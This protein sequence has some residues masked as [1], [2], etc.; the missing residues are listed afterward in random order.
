MK[1]ISLHLLNLI[2][3]FAVLNSS[4]SSEN[5]KETDLET[6]QNNNDEDVTHS[7][8]IDTIDHDFEFMPPSPI[9]IASILKKANMTYED[10]LTNEISNADIYSTKFKQ[11]INFG[12]YACDLAYCVTNDKYEEAGKYLKVAKKMSAKIG[13]ESIFQ[14]DH[15]VERFEKNIGN[16]DSIMDI[17]FHVQ[18]MTDDY[19]HDNDL[20]DLSV[21]YFTGA[22]VEGMNIGTHTILGNDD[23]K[24]SV[25]LSEQM[26]IAK[27]II[28]GLRVVKNQ[29][30][31]LTDLTDHIEEVV[32]AY[33]NLWSVKQEGEN[34]EYLDVELKHEEVV[35]ISEMILE[36]REEII[37]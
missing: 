4:C 27:S 35:S 2:C 36:L 30:D 9:Q 22:W 32:E 34:I 17:L 7:I 6:I 15:L 8:E 3:V 11:T 25:L 19:I 14:S 18:M 28:N 31:D 23:H 20:R 29:T 13:L 12:V 5:T 33:N 24:I 1:K 21:I 16:Q 10:G 26:T 37:M